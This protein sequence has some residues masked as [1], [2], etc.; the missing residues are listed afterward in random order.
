M[1]LATVVTASGTRAG[2]VGEESIELLEFDDAVKVVQLMADGTV[3]NSLRRIGEIPIDGA[4]FA[5]PILRPEKIICVGLNYYGHAAEAKATVPTSPMLFSKYSRAM[6]GAT[7]PIVIPRSTEKCDWEV[8]LGVVIGARVRNIAERD[9]LAA[10]AGYS[11]INDITMRDWQKRT[12]QFLPG[13]TFEAST[14]FGPWIVSPDQIDHARDLELTCSVNGELMQTGRTSDMI[15][16]VAHII[17]YMSEIITLVPG[18]VIAMGTPA[19]IGS[20]RTPPVFLHPGDVVTSA[21][22]G[23]GVLQNVCIGPEGSESHEYV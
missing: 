17:A 19:G 2:I 16:D 8:E 23:I 11:V 6:I 15:F 13:K 12:S 21:I 5:P 9:A 14:P 4:S 7:D 22:E 20:T 3:V 18:D 10:V 1:K